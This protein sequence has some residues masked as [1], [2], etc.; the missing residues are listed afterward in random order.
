MKRKITIPWLVFV[1]GVV[2][3]PDDGIG[4]VPTT[5]VVLLVASV[6]EDGDK[7]VLAPWGCGVVEPTLPGTVLLGAPVG[8][9][10]PLGVPDPLGVVDTTVT[11]PLGAVVGVTDPLGVADPLG[12]VDTAGTVLFGATVGLVSVSYTHL[13]LPTI[14]S[15]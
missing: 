12:V 1:E 4:V 13:T 11:V 15:V 14:Y 8:V 9:T 2:E 10:D 5:G 7:V 6:E 3:V